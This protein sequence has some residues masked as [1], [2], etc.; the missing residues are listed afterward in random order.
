MSNDKNDAG[1]PVIWHLVPPPPATDE[2]TAHEAKMRMPKARR[3]MAAV[4]ETIDAWDI[5][6]ADAEETLRV[7]YEDRTDRASISFAKEEMPKWQQ[8]MESVAWQVADMLPLGLLSP[9]A[10]RRLRA[11]L[12]EYD[13]RAA[14]GDADRL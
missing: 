4:H 14:K 9:M 7:L 1:E 13:A 12:A 5:S 6:E 8:Q 2:I 10:V 3:W 11:G